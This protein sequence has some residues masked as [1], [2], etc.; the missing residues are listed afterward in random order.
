MLE[1][2]TSEPH[3]LT[4]VNVNVRRATG[5]KGAKPDGLVDPYSVITI[6]TEDSVSQ[7]LL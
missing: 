1:H 6:E 3:P 4:I 2:V 7:S 5:L